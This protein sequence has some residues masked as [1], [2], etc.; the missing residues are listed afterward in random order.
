MGPLNF[1]LNPFV[2]PFLL[3]QPEDDTT[4]ST[5]PNNDE[6]VTSFEVIALQENKTIIQNICM[7]TI[8]RN[9]FDQF[10]KIGTKPPPDEVP[11]V[12]TQSCEDYKEQYIN[13]ML[14]KVHLRKLCWETMYGQELVK[15]TI[16]D[17]L[18]TLGNSL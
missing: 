5:I 1:L 9:N 3:E 8:C 7:K 6:V 17:T 14:L 11:I 13:G 15:L 16:M 10:F 4:A 2:Y 18:F 12:V